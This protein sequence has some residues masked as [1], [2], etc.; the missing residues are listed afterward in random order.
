LAKREK[1]EERI[2]NNPSNVSLV[3]FE[4]L[5]NQYGYI[6]EGGSHPQVV[7][8]KRIFSYT[9]TSPVRTP[10]VE[11]LLEIIDSHKKQKNR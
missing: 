7:I 1:R 3:D 4:W 9:R 10:Y 5:A 11:K 2:R 8:G 6:K